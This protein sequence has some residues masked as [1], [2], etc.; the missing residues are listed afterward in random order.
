MKYE[1]SKVEAFEGE[2]LMWSARYDNVIDSWDG[3]AMDEYIAASMGL[4][5]AK[6][7]GTGSLVRS[8]FLI[9]DV[10]TVERW[11][12][13]RPH[14]PRF[15]RRLCR[16]CP[17]HAHLTEPR[18][19]VCSGCGV[20]RYCSEACQAADWPKHQGECCWLLRWAQQKREFAERKV[21]AR[22]PRGRGEAPVA[23][24]LAALE[25]GPGV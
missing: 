5:F 22:A 4:Q 3:E 13:V 24:T 1:S 18:Y 10:R 6:M 17:N 15:R 11:Q 7:V 12:R 20:A 23:N 2:A 25:R 16:F 19:L 14:W 9:T 21:H 8:K